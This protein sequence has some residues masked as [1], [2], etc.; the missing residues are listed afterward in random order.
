MSRTLSWMV[1]A[2]TLVMFGCAKKQQTESGGSLLSGSTTS[3]EEEED[4]GIRDRNP[5]PDGPG[6]T[7]TGAPD[8]RIPR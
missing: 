4:G 6:N 3:E 5:N 2:G 7:G 1:L 8:Q